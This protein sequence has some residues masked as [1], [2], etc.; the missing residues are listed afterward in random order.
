M[1]RLLTIIFCPTPEKTVSS[2]VSVLTLPKHSKARY[3]LITTDEMD[4]ADHFGVDFTTK[5][6]KGI[7][8]SLFNF[9]NDE[10]KEMIVNDEFVPKVIQ[11][12]TTIRE[13]FEKD[14]SAALL[15]IHDNA[16]KLLWD[17][18]VLYS[19][20][21]ALFNIPF[22]LSFRIP[23]TSPMG[24]A[25][26]DCSD[27]NAEVSAKGSLFKQESIV[28]NSMLFLFLRTNCE[29]QTQVQSLI[30]LSF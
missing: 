28:S 8:S 20:I 10:G 3:V 6:K 17:W 19:V 4:S 9:R 25:M 1:Y 7:F 15:I 22:E 5:K 16:P 14:N 11:M 21:W 13:E 12:A 29:F 26:A 23:C 18:I 30:P 2:M 24:T 27:M